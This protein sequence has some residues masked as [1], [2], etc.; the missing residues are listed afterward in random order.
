MTNKDVSPNGDITEVIEALR[1]AVVSLPRYSFLLDPKGNVRRVSSRS[2]NWIELSEVHKLF[3]PE[4]VDWFLSRE[5]AKAV[6]A[7]AKSKDST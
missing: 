2:G 4:V 6:I 5:R 1:Q 3:D 7:V